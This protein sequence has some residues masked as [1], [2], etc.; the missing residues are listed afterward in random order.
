MHRQL[1]FVPGAPA[2]DLA[3][4]LHSVGGKSSGVGV[5]SAWPC[6][7]LTN[8]WTDDQWMSARVQACAA[9]VE[10][11]WFKIGVAYG[12]AADTY[13]R[14]TMDK[15]DSILA[16][17]TERIVRQSHGPRLIVGDFNHGRNSLT[18]FAI[19]RASGFV[20][21]QEY[22]LQKWGRSIAAT[23]KGGEAIDQVWISK[24]L[25][26]Y[27]QSV[28]TDDAWFPGHS[29]LYGVFSSLGKQQPVSVWRKPLALP[30]EDVPEL[31][32]AEP[33]FAAT[34]DPENLFADVFHCLESRMDRQLH[35]EGKPGL[36]PQQKGR[37]LTSAPTRR[38]APITPVKAAR[39]GE[40]GVTFLGEHFLHVK[41]CRQL[42]R[43]QSLIKLQKSPKTSS[44][45]V[46][47][48][49]ELW[50]SIRRASGFPKGF[51]Y[52]WANRTVRLPGAPCV[53]PK[54][55]PD[56]PV[57][58]L[59]FHSFLT[60]FRSLETALLR[61][62]QAEA[63]TRRFADKN[64]AF[65]DVARPQSQ[66]VQTLL[67]RKS[68]CITEVSARQIL[69]EPHT[70]LVEEPVFGPQGLLVVDVHEPGCLT[71]KQEATV[72]VGDVLTQEVLI[73]KLEDMFSAFRQLWDPMWNRHQ[74][75]PV[76]AWDSVVRKILDVLPRPPQPFLLTPVTEEQ[77]LS[78][79]RRRKKRSAP[80][81]DGVARSDLLGMPPDLVTET[82]R[83]VNAIE[84][85]LHHW[86]N[87]CMVGLISNLEKHDRASVPSHYRPIT[88]LSQ[89][90]RTWGSLRTK[91]VLQWMDTFCPSTLAGNRPSMSTHHVWHCLSQ[92]LE[93]AQ[94]NQ[95]R[96]GGIVA[97]I[98]K[99]FNTLPRPVVI[100]IALH[101]G[102]P[103]S[104]V[105]CWHDA[106]TRVQ[107]RFLI[108][109]SCSEPQFSQTG[110]PE[111]DGL[112]I[113]AMSLINYA[114]HALVGE[115]LQQT[116][117]HSYVDNWEVISH[118]PSEL[119]RAFCQM[120]QFAKD[121]DV[122]ID[123]R[124]THC[125]ALDSADRAQL[126]TLALEV[127]YDARDLGG[128][129]VYCRKRTMQTIK[130]RIATNNVGW[131]WLARS[132]A[133][134][135][136]KLSLLAT[137]LWP[138][139]LHG[140]SGL[141][142]GAEHCKKLRSSAMQSLKW[143]K[144]GAS[145]LV[146]MGLGMDLKADPGYWVLAST[147]MDF[148]RYAH[149]E[150]SIAVVT[151]LAT[152]AYP[153]YTNGPCGA[154]LHR[155]HEIHWRW[156]GNGY[157]SD[158]EMLSLHLW[159]TPIQHLLARL[160][161]GW[162]KMVGGLASDRATFDGLQNVNLV[163]THAST[164]KFRPDE[165]G[166]LRAAMN[167][168]FFTRDAQ[169]H[170][171]IAATKQC[172]FCDDQD[173]VYHRHLLCPEFNDLRMMIPAEVRERLLQ[174]PDCVKVR[175]WMTESTHA[176]DFRRALQQVP[177]Q[178]EV[179]V[180]KMPTDPILH[181]F[182]D[183]SC[184]ESTT[185]AL[186]LATWAVSHADMSEVA[187]HPVSSGGVPGGLQT[188]LRG[189]I[190][191]AISAVKFGTSVR[192]P[193]LI[194]TDNQLVHDALRQMLLHSY[195]LPGVTKPDHDLWHVLYSAVS[196]AIALGVF[197]NVVKVRSHEDAGQYA[198]CV[199][200][201]A[202]SGNDEA[203]RLAILAR[204]SLPLSLRV[205]WQ[206]FVRDYRLRQLDID[207]MH[208]LIVN[209]GL[210][211]VSRKKELAKQAE[212]EWDAAVDMP[213][214]PNAGEVS[215]GA[216]VS[217]ESL[218]AKSTLRVIAKAL[219]EWMISF[220]EG[221]DRALFWLSSAHLLV[222]Y[223][224]TTGDLGF[225]F[226][227]ATNQWNFALERIERDGF[228]FQQSANWLQAAIRCYA[229]AA[230]MRYDCQIRMPDGGCYRCWAP[231]LQLRFSAA[232]FWRIDGALKAQGA[233]AIKSPKKDFKNLK[234][235]VASR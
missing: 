54:Q 105:S 20:E 218:P 202:I 49:R 64:V 10:G 23:G 65:R 32:C 42:R 73:G 217:W 130:S 172:P 95:T 185:P 193:F 170:A 92:T 203:D 87:S 13:T 107:R 207:H 90:Y 125:W 161:D 151:D 140:V 169:Y 31:T 21:L 27:L 196:K 139:M 141:W 211:V 222:H 175:G 26:P 191:A 223:Q 181:L 109:G 3:T 62:R 97:D 209:I 67:D 48:K 30:W 93:C 98:V 9:L 25:I 216:V 227:Q 53:L 230:S 157:L 85:G 84:D 119:Q 51:P 43:L 41:W 115:N 149:T 173:S 58:E 233:V 206:R 152:G 44:D 38:T 214:P 8:A 176:L 136:Q 120:E 61:H 114:M 122:K 232:M 189:E 80:G 5:I 205:S 71:L 178:S 37:C 60:E 106:V 79:V 101:V 34:S 112:S 56:L 164:A 148:R 145:S 116:A 99:C 208:R 150:A 153:R 39:K 75:L 94:V 50:I 234:P 183:G 14:S 55:V 212:Q 226:N 156:E 7:A 158:H 45:L 108:D 121:I 192:R 235:F 167:G 133:P 28:H 83:V 128:H 198:C 195:K 46:V 1:K 16:L 182:T 177:D 210:R 142:I 15:T 57:C 17:L 132:C 180:C 179:F 77:W 135:S 126:R 204:D 72:T 74:D 96:L 229:R 11:V 63:K 24:E 231:C 69:Y 213:R 102:L 86:P 118:D 100:A 199:E 4:S 131:S 197:E 155:L 200:K 154:V 19:W 219:C 78:E 168:T 190:W 47:H 134:V 147:V 111:G 33:P 187:F 160:K 146:Q 91:Q 66:P 52:A 201:W 138:R 162:A 2:P 103:R 228:C 68:V 159:D 174:M 129:V 36:L 215:L 184:A 89:C 6:R 35:A 143:Q 76:D 70:L 194:W 59:I 113:V 88:V 165:A 225:C 40:V 110:Y 186:R 12:F 221:E 144:K 171:S 124:K 22:A 123:R 166:L 82:V 163:L 29:I 81:P 220:D 224:M 117:V 137:V 127:K 18:Q 104:F 188:V